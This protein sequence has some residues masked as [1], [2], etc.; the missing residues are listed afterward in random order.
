MAAP[1]NRFERVRSPDPAAVT[2][3]I[4]GEDGRSTGQ[5]RGPEPMGGPVARA[6]TFGE[7]DSLSAHQAL[8][9]GCHLANE[10]GVSVVVIDEGGH[11]RPAWGS[12]AA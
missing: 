5:V 6:L 3:T 1:G 9:V 8:A 4:G 10:L 2:V 7:D 12:L 11:W